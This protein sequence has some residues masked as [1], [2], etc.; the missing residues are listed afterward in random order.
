VGKGLKNS[1]FYLYQAHIFSLMLFSVDNMHYFQTRSSVHEI[2][3]VYKNQLHIPSIRLTAIEECPTYSAIKIFNKLPP[4]IS[5]LNLFVKSALRKYLLTHH[6]FIEEFLPNDSRLFIFRIVFF[7]SS[8]ASIVRL[9][10]LFF[11][12]LHSYLLSVM[13]GLYLL[14]SL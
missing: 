4:R 3:T 10:R 11:K 13:L 5:G 8:S 12:L 14:Y 6:F 9:Y 2:N 1:I 7:I